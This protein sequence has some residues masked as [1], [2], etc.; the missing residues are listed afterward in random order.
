MSERKC[1]HCEG[2]GKVADTDE[3]EPWTAWTSVPLHSSIAVVMGMVKP[4][5]CEYCKGTG[6]DPIPV[7]LD[8][9]E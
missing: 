9:G 5:P 1:Q 6:V 3:R 7:F 8:E 2:C 4:I